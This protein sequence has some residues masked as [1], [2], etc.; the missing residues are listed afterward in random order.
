MTRTATL[1]RPKSAE[2]VCSPTAR[3][4]IEQ[5]QAE[6]QAATL[7]VLSAKD[8]ITVLHGL[9]SRTKRVIFGND[10]ITIRDDRGSFIDLY[11]RRHLPEIWKNMEME[12]IWNPTHWYG[13]TT[14]VDGNDVEWYRQLNTMVCNDFGDLVAVKVGQP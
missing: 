3:K 9:D 5:L 13:S 10:Y 6:A 7:E 2:V 11:Q 14:L 8:G 4:L 1:K 12:A